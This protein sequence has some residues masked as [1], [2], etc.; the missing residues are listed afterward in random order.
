MRRGSV[1][2][3]IPRDSVVYFERRDGKDWS[4]ITYVAAATTV[5]GYLVGDELA[6]R[7]GGGGTETVGLGYGGLFGAVGGA[8]LGAGIGICVVP[9]RW[10]SIDVG[11][12]FR[13]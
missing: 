10:S 12:V 4:T 7:S 2:R 5:F 9:N 11:F 8:L 13:R 6:R 3:F 1:T